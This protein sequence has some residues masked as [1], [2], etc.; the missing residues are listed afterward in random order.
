MF[1]WGVNTYNDEEL[2]IDK[3]IDIIY[4][5]FNKGNQN[6][7]DFMGNHHEEIYT[8]DNFGTDWSCQIDSLSLSNAKPVMK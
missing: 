2:T 5:V 8:Q 6:L 3:K 7:S 4:D 1:Y